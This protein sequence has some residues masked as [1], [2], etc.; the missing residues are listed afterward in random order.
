[1]I[2]F[3]K[4]NRLIAGVFLVVCV[5]LVLIG[6]I[7]LSLWKG[8][9][10]EEQE[11]I[12]FGNTD[13]TRMFTEE[14]LLFGSSS[15]KWIAKEGDGVPAPNFRLLTTTPAMGAVSFLKG[16]LGE[17]VRF[18]SRTNG[19]IFDVP[20]T[21]IG[22]EEKL[23]NETILRIGNVGW[24]QNGA[25]TFTQY[26][27]ETG[28]K[29]KTYLR[30]L[31]DTA[32]TSPSTA[33]STLKGRHIEDQIVSSSLSPKGDSIFY[34]VKNDTGS[35]GYIENASTGKR[36]Q[37]WS[38][39]LTNVTSAWEASNMVLVYTNP[40]SI[41]HGVLWSL[42]P[43]TGKVQAILKNMTALSAKSNKQGDKILFSM[44]EKETGAFSLRVLDVKTGETTQLGL[45]TMTEK[46]SWGNDSRY[47]YCA[48]P[49][50]A[51]AGDFLENW[52]MGLTESDDIIWR[53]DTE[54]GTTKMLFDPQ[55]ETKESFDIIDITPSPEEDYLVFRTK[56]KSGLWAY[57]LPVETNATSTS[58]ENA[59]STPSE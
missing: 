27:D 40:S 28:E 32:S 58:P 51:V 31:Q 52:Y 14:E 25:T 59:T 57:K 3:F 35:I 12:S 49:R 26:L 16:E 30:S 45:A 56:V 5:L 53:L 13:E 24:S 48:I 4:K 11:E 47:V 54:I 21:V 46:C 2:D 33:S 23:A 9:V 8:G 43:S 44:Q 22:P 41:A 1:M 10:E 34:I 6:V 17:Y 55:T 36:T 42:Q 29:I 19:N 50:N 37:V 38:S 18:T 20:L 7:L 15:D 39:I